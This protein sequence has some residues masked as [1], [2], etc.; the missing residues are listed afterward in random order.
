MDLLGFLKGVAG[1][2]C[3]WT[4]FF[5]GESVVGCVVDVEFQHHVFRLRK[6]C[7]LF[8]IYFSLGWRMWLRTLAMTDSGWP[9]S[10]NSVGG[11][12]SFVVAVTFTV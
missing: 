9:P 1:K 5:G 10:A 7:Q 3:G 8:E 4:W 12:P 6:I 11:Q 2:L